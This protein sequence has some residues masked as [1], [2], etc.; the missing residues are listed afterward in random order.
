MLSDV[1]GLFETVAVH[2]D[3]ISSMIIPLK[4]DHSN[5]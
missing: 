3:A 5:D 4:C 2:P 1:E